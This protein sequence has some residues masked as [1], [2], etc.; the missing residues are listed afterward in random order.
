M[1]TAAEKT[2]LVTLATIVLLTIPLTPQQADTPSQTK[3]Q[4]IRIE[5]AH[6]MQGEVLAHGENAVSVGKYKVKTYRLERVKLSQPLLLTNQQP[7]EYAYKLIVTGG[8]FNT[9]HLIWADDRPFSAV[10]S[11]NGTE[12]VAVFLN[13]PNILDDDATLSVTQGWNPCT[14][15]PDSESVLPE[16][17]TVP[18]ELR[19]APR[20][21][22]S[23]RLRTVPRGREYPEYLGKPSISIRVTTTQIIAGFYNEDVAIQIGKASFRAGGVLHDIGAQVPH[24]VFSHIP[25]NAEVFVKRGLCAT[26]GEFVGRLNK[27][28]LDH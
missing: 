20:D 26:G 10:P 17:L 22:S 3:Q 2:F 16:K 11:Q 5:N 23:I 19:A 9:T 7:Y 24:D 12:L 1:H 27:S 28:T 14:V 4:E 6:R 21:A 13:G 15:D 25:D 8:P 18:Y